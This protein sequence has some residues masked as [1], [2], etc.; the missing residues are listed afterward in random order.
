VNDTTFI[1]LIAFLVLFAGFQQW[2]RHQRRVMV[3]RERLAA[4]ERGVELPPVEQE[5]RNTERTVQRVLLFAGLVWL[6]VGIA[7]YGVLESLV[8]QPP[9]HVQ[10]GHDR[11]GNPQWVEVP[12][13]DGVEWIGVAIAGIGISHLVVYFANRQ[14][15]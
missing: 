9:F 3:H 14:K 15:N 2:I 6:F 10:W 7:S 1:L 13:R 8:G 12:V 11:F 4:I 5:T